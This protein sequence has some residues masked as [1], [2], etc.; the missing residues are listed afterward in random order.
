MISILQ[1]ATLQTKLLSFCKQYTVHYTQTVYH[2]L[3]IWLLPHTHNNHLHF[4][5]PYQ[6]KQYFFKQLNPKGVHI[7]YQLN[8]QGKELPSTD[9]INEISFQIVQI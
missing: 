9:H 4:P 7:N 1:S 8:Y 3:C 2:L 5:P 6:T